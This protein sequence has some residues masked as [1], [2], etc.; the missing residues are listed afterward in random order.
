M[1]TKRDSMIA[2]EATAGA[3]VAATAASINMTFGLAMLFV[4]G[5]ELIFASIGLLLNYW[6]WHEW[7]KNYWIDDLGDWLGWFVLVFIYAVT[8]ALV[9]KML[10]AK[11][12]LPLMLFTSIAIAFYSYG[13]LMSTR[14][15]DDN[16]WVI[17]GVICLVEFLFLYQFIVCLV[18]T[19]KWQPGIPLYLDVD[20]SWQFLKKWLEKEHG[21]ITS[22]FVVF[23]YFA[24][25]W[26]MFL[27]P[28][29]RAMYV[30]EFMPEALYFLH[31]PA[32]LTDYIRGWLVH[33]L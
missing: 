28:I 31:I 8:W 17:V 7:I 25:L 6:M 9:V 5:V 1:S 20:P 24:F 22:W 4:G 29:F 13:W 21:L 23:L 3:A 18:A 32:E 16:D 19:K 14:S 11:R 15:F 33:G 12:L 26:L 27:S 30:Q 10:T 2:V